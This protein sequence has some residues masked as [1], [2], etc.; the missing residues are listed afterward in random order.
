MQSPPETAWLQRL[1]AAWYGRRPV[2]A[3]VP[4]SLLFGAVAALRRLLFR[5]GVRSVERL[6]VPVVVVGN[7]VVG[8]AGKTPL[9][10]A[11]AAALRAAGRRP[12]VIS[13]GYGGRW[14]QPALVQAGTDAADCGDEALLIARSVDV[15]VAVARRRAEAARLLLAAHPECDLLLCDDGLQHYALAR[16]VELVV[17]DAA[18]GFGNGWLL[19]A[20][21]LREP[22]GRLRSVQGVLLHGASPDARA[23][24]ALQSALPAGLPV[25]QPHLRMDKPLSLGGA[26]AR[27]WPVWS[28]TAVHAVAG[29][30]NPARFFA[31]LREQGLRVTE[32]A[33][34]DH[35]AYAPAELAIAGTAPVLL[36]AK[37]AVKC[38]WLVSTRYWVVP[39]VAELP[40]G[41]LPWLLELLETTRGRENP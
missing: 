39:L 12:G 15:P 17:V 9:V 41:L 27:D 36:T 26:G 11:L 3:L 29:I 4:L 32:H 30:G 2:L 5:S 18:R 25:W 24:Q 37:D 22:L 34:P 14:R 20:G 21:P 16:D 35:H 23:A 13:R 38:P 33:F 6:P 1:P 8:G 31:G 19:P 7:L 40:A 10:I 28:G